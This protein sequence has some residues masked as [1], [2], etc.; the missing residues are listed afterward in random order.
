LQEVTINY[1]LRNPFLQKIKVQSIDFQLIGSNLLVWD[2]VKLFDP[3]QA[4]RN[5]EVY[6]IPTT[7]TLQ[8]YIN[9]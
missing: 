4:Q 2:K 7:Y 6:P 5:G 8:M 9:L 1:N 3:E